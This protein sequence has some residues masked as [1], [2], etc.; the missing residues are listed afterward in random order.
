MNKYRYIQQKEYRDKETIVLYFDPEECDVRE[1]VELS[2][3]ALIDW[4]VGFNQEI[5]PDERQARWGEIE[6]LSR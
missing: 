1:T 4:L 3:D 5:G 6:R 2:R